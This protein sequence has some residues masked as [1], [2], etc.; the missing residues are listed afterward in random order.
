MVVDPFVYSDDNGPPTGEPIPCQGTFALC[1]Q[2][3]GN[4]TAA[5]NLGGQVPREQGLGTQIQE[6]SVVF[7]NK[8]PLNLMINP[9]QLLY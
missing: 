8:V 3:H 5:M 6:I 7:E 2:G 4:A 9:I 1:H